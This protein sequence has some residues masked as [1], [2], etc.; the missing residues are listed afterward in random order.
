MV[1]ETFPRKLM[2]K[3]SHRQQLI[4]PCQTFPIPT[5]LIEVPM[6]ENRKLIEDPR[7]TEFSLNFSKTSA[8]DMAHKIIMKSISAI[9]F[10]AQGYAQTHFRCEIL[11]GIVVRDN[12]KAM[13][14]I[15][16]KIP[17][18]SSNLC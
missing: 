2:A 13:K 18:S 16:G 15:V 1:A 7:L 12:D 5:A 9:M 4:T 10:R 17:H 8:V 3:H 11:I 6:H 14:F